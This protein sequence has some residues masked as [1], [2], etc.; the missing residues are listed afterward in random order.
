MTRAIR[1]LWH[2]FWFLLMRISVRVL[3]GK[4]PVMVLANAQITGPLEID[5]DSVA[6]I[7]NCWF[8]RE[9]QGSTG[10]KE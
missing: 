6:F 2:G 8:V 9:S 10:V 5:K 4:S 7:W 1:K 3:A